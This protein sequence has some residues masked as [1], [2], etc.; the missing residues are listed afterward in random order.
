MSHY[1]DTID[2]HILK[3][4][5]WV[6]D[7]LIDAGMY[8]TELFFG[9]EYANA[10]VY[11]NQ[12]NGDRL[13]KEKF[14]EYEGLNLHETEEWEL[15]SQLDS[16]AQWY[17]VTDQ[18]G[19]YLA[20]HGEVIAWLPIGCVWGRASYGEAIAQTGVIEDFAIEILCFDPADTKI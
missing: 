11:I 5:S 14:G 8:Q 19:A 15:S 9:C 10:E 16:V 3:H 7:K 18:L 2:K 1:T 4:F 12:E 17:L 20:D 6:M 13:T